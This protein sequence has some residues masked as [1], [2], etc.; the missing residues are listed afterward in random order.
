MIA[1]ALWQS[2]RQSSRSGEEKPKRALGR[3]GSS[4]YC[5]EV[6]HQRGYC[7]LKASELIASVFV[8]AH[9]ETP[10]IK[11]PPGGGFCFLVISLDETPARYVYVG[12]P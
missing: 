2:G 3:K 7:P 4:L 12:K 10:Q 6:C 11:K 9:C 1:P 8:F 5:I